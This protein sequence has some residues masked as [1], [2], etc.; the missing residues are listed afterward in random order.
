M[1]KIE[2]NPNLNITVSEFVTIINKFRILNK[3]SWYGLRLTVN[4]KTVEIKGYNTWLQIF[5]IDG[6]NQNTCM[7]VTVKEFKLTLECAFN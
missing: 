7:D 3:N 6:I 2:Y 5:R 1:K 4:N